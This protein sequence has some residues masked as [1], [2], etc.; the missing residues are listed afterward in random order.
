MGKEFLWAQHR[1]FLL[2]RVRRRDFRKSRKACFWKNARPAPVS[3]DT[4]A[5]A[6]VRSRSSSNVNC[7]LATRVRNAFKTARDARTRR[8]HRSADFFQRLS[9]RF[10]RPS[11]I[12]TRAC[13]GASTS[14]GT[15]ACDGA[16][17]SKNKACTSDRL[18]GHLLLLMAVHDHADPGSCARPGLQTPRSRI[19]HPPAPPPLGHIPPRSR[20]A[21]PP[22]DPGS[23]TRPRSRICTHIPSLGL[24]TQ[25]M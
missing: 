22:H 13:D 24:C 12:G 21:H 3:S 7:S 4:P 18:R 8:I 6:D 1:R 9:K 25:K 17:S 23:C 10:R 16:S 11:L 15:T 2:A 5:S 14:I 19:V 20:I